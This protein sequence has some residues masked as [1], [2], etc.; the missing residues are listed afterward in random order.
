MLAWQNFPSFCLGIQNDFNI[1]EDAPCFPEFLV[2]SGIFGQNC[3]PAI[4]TGV[5]AAITG[6]R[7]L[8]KNVISSHTEGCL[9][10]RCRRSKVL[11]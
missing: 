5:G 9:S 7:F 11:V 4:C 2:P 6:K 8:V 3:L 1:E 10:P